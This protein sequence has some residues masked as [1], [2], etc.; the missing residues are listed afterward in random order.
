MKMIIE[1]ALISLLLLVPSTISTIPVSFERL[2]ILN[3]KGNI[4]KTIDMIGDL[5]IRPFMVTPKGPS[6][7]TAAYLKP[8][9][10][11]MFITPERTLLATLRQI[12][13]SFIKK[14]ISFELLWELTPLNESSLELYKHARSAEESALVKRAYEILF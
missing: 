11:L 9:E 1:A 10:T 4:T 14:N 6:K 7:K 12:I 3:E 13:D 5:H 8:V 2:V